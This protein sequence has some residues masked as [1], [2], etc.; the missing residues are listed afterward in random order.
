[1]CLLFLNMELDPRRLRVLLNVARAGGV[2]AAAAEL[3]LSP[4]AVSQQ[5][6]RL[7][8][9]AGTLLIDRTPR[10][11][12]LTPAGQVVVEAAEE[13][14]RTL[15]VARARLTEAGTDVRGRV[16]LASFA[17]FLRT[18]VAPGLP[19]WRARYPLLEVTIAEHDLETATRLLRRGELDIAIVEL[20]SADHTEG[21]LP[22]GIREDPLLDE[23]WRLVVP[24]GTLA[25]AHGLVPNL[26]LPW[27]ATETSPATAAAIDRLREASGDPAPA[28][29]H[30]NETLTGLA[31]V[32]AGQGMTVM[33][34]LA[35][36]GLEH[37]GV[38]V[39]EVPGLGTRRIVARR[40]ARKPAPSTP[41]DTLVRLVQ[42]AARSLDLTGTAPG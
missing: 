28:V 36:H 32:A 39:L 17:S 1:M 20:D 9:E 34:V 24:S 13:I 16:R 6:S 42:Q 4:S 27:L 26:S 23:P 35:L 12:V 33:P 38:D 8:R 22:A 19:A 15:S 31:L 10:G 3:R 40:L 18:V 21:A 2:L 7:E 11:S 30:Y 41:V 25:T 5:L 14:E 37:P 29:H